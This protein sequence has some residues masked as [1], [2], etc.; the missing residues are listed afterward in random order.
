MNK[1]VL[2]VVLA[3]LAV[4]AL[5]GCG[6]D[7]SNPAPPPVRSPATPAPTPSRGELAGLGADAIL[8][9]AGEAL[10]RAGSFHLKGGVAAGLVVPAPP[11]AGE[12]VLDL[13]IA[14]NDMVG[15]VLL[16]GS[17][18][19]L[20]A[21]GGHCYLRPG[22]EFWHRADPSGRARRVLG[23]RWIK[24]D[25]GANAA[26][27]GF[28]HPA[29][30]V[31]ELLKPEGPV[32]KGGTRVIGGV[33]AIALLD[34]DNVLYVAARGEPYPLL[35]ES[36]GAAGLVFDSFGAT[37]RGIRPPAPG[38]A[39]DLAALKLGKAHPRNGSPALVGA[40]DD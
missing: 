18:G 7:R 38:Q 35:L 31:R 12:A 11:P 28:F 16:P 13:R 5:G 29:V 36:P 3:A 23:D 20:L 1:S 25:T 14:G 33:P 30:T 21:V 6:T 15:T 34:G 4:A 40:A 27:A 10:R 22:A 17:S 37:F 26:L 32:R 2:R 9:R 19:Q 39:I 24:A 8:A